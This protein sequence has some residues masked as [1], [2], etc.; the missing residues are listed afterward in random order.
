MLKQ[1]GV[2]NASEIV[3]KRLAVQKQYAAM[4]ANKHGDALIGEVNSLILEDGQLSESEQEL[5][6][7]SL[8]KEIANNIF[9]ME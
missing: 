7:Y 1:M 3:T 5:A 6:A 8:E 9:Q 4:S 2:A